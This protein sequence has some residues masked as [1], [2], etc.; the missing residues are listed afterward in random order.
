MIHNAKMAGSFNLSRAT[1]EAINKSTHIDSHEKVDHLEKA[2]KNLDK[3][4]RCLDFFDILVK[5]GR[6]VITT[7]TTYDRVKENIKEYKE[8]L[9]TYKRYVEQTHDI[10]PSDE[11]IIENCTK[12]LVQAGKDGFTLWKSLVNVGAFC[13][14]KIPCKAEDLQYIL[15]GVNLNILQINDNLQAGCQR[16]RTYM[17]LRMWRWGAKVYIP[18][19]NGEVCDAALERWKS[20]A[21]SISKSTLEENPYNPHS[22]WMK[23]EGSLGG[24]YNLH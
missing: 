18:R 8:L 3:Y 20:R 13:T 4:M 7:K 9:D 5:A 19:S 16:L 6:V 1:V 12:T 15:T 14:G 11:Y 10:R 21:L 22:D 17:N 24:K 2:S 23:N